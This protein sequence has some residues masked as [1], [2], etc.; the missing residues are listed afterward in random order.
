MWGWGSRGLQWDLGAQMTRVHGREGAGAHG[1]FAAEG[2]SGPPAPRGGQLCVCRP[3]RWGEGMLPVHEATGHNSGHTGA[4]SM[5]L[6]LQPG[7][8]LARVAGRPEGREP[9]LRPRAS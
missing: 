1:I 3:Q 2:E 6:G 8:G 7:S 9:S 5:S 4:A